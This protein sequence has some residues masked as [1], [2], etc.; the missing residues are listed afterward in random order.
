VNNSYSSTTICN[1]GYSGNDYSNISF[2]ARMDNLGEPDI[3]FIY[4]ATNDSRANS[5]IGDYKYAGWTN[6]DLYQFRPAMAHMLYYMTNHYD[7]AK[8]YFLLNDYLKDEIKESVRT[9]CAHYGVT[10]ID[11]V[12]LDLQT[13][14]PSILGMEQ[15]CTQITAFLKK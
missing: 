3:I 15:I 1:T 4:G 14:H 2:I 13:R 12:G 10:C 8:I 9:I 7:Y 5:P 6:E 11:M